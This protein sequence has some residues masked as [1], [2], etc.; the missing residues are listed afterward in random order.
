[1]LLY[2]Q[3]NLCKTETAGQ[4]GYTTILHISFN[5]CDHFPLDVHL[6]LFDTFNLLPMPPRP[7]H[8]TQRNRT[9][10]CKKENPRFRVSH[11]RESYQGSHRSNG[12]MMVADGYMQL[13]LDL[14][15]VRSYT[16]S[17]RITVPSAMLVR[18]IVLLR[19]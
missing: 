16:P 3:A 12:D 4:R 8:T 18:G 6:L 13:N 7:S 1:M 19:R 9:A 10:Q 2:H 15:S 14:D 5:T 11:S 17:P